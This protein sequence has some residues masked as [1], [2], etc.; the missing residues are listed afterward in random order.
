[1]TGIGGLE[2]EA[3]RALLAELTDA[4]TQPEYVYAHKWRIGDV[5]M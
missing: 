2:E 4:A 1:M 5:V 3:G